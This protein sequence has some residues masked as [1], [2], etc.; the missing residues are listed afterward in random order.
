MPFGSSAHERPGWVGKGL[1]GLFDQGATSGSNFLLNVLL[2]RWLAPAEYGAF[3]VASACFYA[4]AGLHVA[5]LVEP[6][7]V[8]GPTRYA[9]RI[10]AYLGALVRGHVGLASVLALALACGAA[11][12][13]AAGSAVA[14]PLFGVA[15]ALPFVLLLWLLRQ[16]CY[17]ETKPA[18]AL[19]GSAVYA[20]VLLAA[21]VGMR[22][23]GPR[24]AI[25]APSA[26]AAMAVASAAASAVLWRS[27]G[28]DHRAGA[29]LLAEQPLASEHWRFGRWITAATVANVIGS[30]LYAPIVGG[31]AGL[32]QSGAYRALL[33]LVLPIQQA[34]AAVGL[35]ALPWLA[36]RRAASGPRAAAQATARLVAAHLGLSGGYVLVLSLLGRRVLDLVYGRGAYPG[37]GS[38][39]PLVGASVVIAAAGQAFAIAL[40]A[41]EAPHAIFWSK[42]ASAVLF[43]GAGLPLIGRGG[44]RGAVV[45]M[46]VAAAG[47]A[48]VLAAL[49]WS[50]RGTRVAPLARRG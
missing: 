20:L 49:A 47:E 32:G 43:V 14:A 33:N 12:T 9:D 11:V 21:I 2:A 5:L 41:S 31:V 46:I 50:S 4:V 23:L 17:L 19:R 28:V 3:A 45:T 10:P 35:L 1:A 13:L 42:A 6:M 39:I 26:F 37:I 16:A 18:L 24:S 48:A 38:L 44:L 40:R 29:A 30:G 7:N 22:L 34:L 15:A 27:L 8:L 25:S 36:R